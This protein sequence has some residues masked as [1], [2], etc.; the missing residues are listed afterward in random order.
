[1]S[2]VFPKTINSSKVF[3]TRM[4]EV[5]GRLDPFYFRPELVAMEEKVRSVP[6][7]RLRDY[8]VRMAG[9]ATPSTTESDTHY[10]DGA[11]GVPFIRVQNL[12]TTGRLNLNDCKRITRRTHEGLL[13]RSKLSGGELLVKITGVGRMAVASVVPDDFEG[14]INQHIVAIRT[15]DTQTSETLAAYLN[16][17]I[18]ERLASRRSSGGTRPALDYPALLSIPIVFDARIPE[19][20]GRAVTK[21]EKKCSTAKEL[22]GQIDELLLDELGIKLKPEP[23]NTVKSRIFQTRFDRLTGQRWDAFYFQEKF[24]IYNKSISQ[25]K[26]P[27]RSLAKMLSFIESGSRPSGGVKNIETGILSF[28]GE[29]IN[30]IGEIELKNPRYIPSDYHEANKTTETRLGDILLVKDGATTGKAGII[31]QK[32]HVGQNINEHLFILR[33]SEMM[34]GDYLF[35]FLYSRIGQHLLRREITGATVTGLTKSVVMKLLI[36][37]PPLDIQDRI[38]ERIAEICQKASE[39]RSQA[40][41]ELNEAKREIEAMILGAKTGAGKPSV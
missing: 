32:A 37:N 16:L 28:G 31:R 15:K 18:A 29:H 4:S 25:G 27:C 35:Y 17:D 30:A 23:P 26:Y 11:E 12:S 8:V 34:K 7:H 33:T 24:E 14:N 13:A 22:L 36:P 39:L 5:T 10:T 1:M 21:Y 19:L 2:F 6:P 38:C 20:V 40:V 3:L 9:G 41:G